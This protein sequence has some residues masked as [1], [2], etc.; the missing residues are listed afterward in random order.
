M[1][2][3]PA[4][5][6]RSNSRPAWSPMIQS[7]CFQPITDGSSDGRS[8]AVGACSGVGSRSSDSATISRPSE[9][10]TT[11]SMPERAAR[12]MRI[13]QPNHQAM[14]SKVAGP[15][16]RSQ[17]ETSRARID[18]WSEVSMSRSEIIHV[19][20]LD[21]H[22]PPGRPRTMRPSMARRETR[23][24]STGTSPPHFPLPITI[25][26]ADSGTTSESSRVEIPGRS[27]ITASTASVTLDIHRS[28]SSSSPATTRPFLT[29]RRSASA[30]AGET[31]ACTIAAW[32]RAITHSV[33]RIACSRTS[34]RSS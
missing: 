22:E 24:L 33:L 32:S 28:G 13:P 1:T 20:W 15:K 21:T 29:R 12:V 14:S 10:M 3:G 17:S 34:V 31:A 6:F 11:C 18:S 2:M 8:T 19:Y 27:R 25:G 30:T 7:R 9:V 5:P 23:R 26:C 4:F 16:E